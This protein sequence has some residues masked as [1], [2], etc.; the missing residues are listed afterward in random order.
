MHY[1]V[2]DVKRVSFASE[3]R[4]QIDP[5]EWK[6]GLEVLNEKRCSG[7]LDSPGVRNPPRTLLFALT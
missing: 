3:S 7:S 2:D 1:L 4:N 6:S 5:P